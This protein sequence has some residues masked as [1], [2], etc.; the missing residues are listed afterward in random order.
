MMDDVDNSNCRRHDNVLYK[1]TDHCAGW[2][3]IQ[4]KKSIAIRIQNSTPHSNHHT[5]AKLFLFS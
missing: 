4:S 5:E 3:K 2:W 1:K